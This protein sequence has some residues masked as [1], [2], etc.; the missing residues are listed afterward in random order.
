MEACP[1]LHQLACPLQEHGQTGRTCPSGLP[2]GA[3]LV[4]GEG[5][6]IQVVCL[7][8][9]AG[10]RD[11]DGDALSAVA[12]AAPLHIASA[13]SAYELHISTL[14]SEATAMCKQ[15]CCPSCIGY[16]MDT[17]NCEPTSFASA[18]SCMMDAWMQSKTCQERWCQ[19]ALQF[20]FA[21]Q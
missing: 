21:I 3:H 16:I 14:Q 8:L 18:V 19:L 11:H 6:E 12:I 15:P 1:C 13:V 9:W 10:I 4:V 2:S 20:S 17:R 7:T 5:L